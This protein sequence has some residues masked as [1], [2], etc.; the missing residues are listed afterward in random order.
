MCKYCVIETGETP[1]FRPSRAKVLLSVAHLHE[2]IRSR[3]KLGIAIPYSLG[4]GLYFLSMHMLRKQGA[5]L[6]LPS[7]PTVLSFT[8]AILI[9]LK[10]T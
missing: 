4:V 10:F 5:Y 9:S 3:F 7:S 1:T 2:Y 6:C 8:F